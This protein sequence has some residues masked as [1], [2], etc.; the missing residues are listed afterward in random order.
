MTFNLRWIYFCTIYVFWKKNILKKAVLKFLFVFLFFIFSVI[1]FA[2]F[3][4]ALLQMSTVKAEYNWQH[5]NIDPEFES[6]FPFSLSR[7]HIVPAL[8]LKNINF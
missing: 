6:G 3:I 8:T 1:K 4:C 7:G 2:F 5:E